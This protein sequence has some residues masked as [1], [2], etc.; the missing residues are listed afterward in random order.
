MVGFLTNFHGY[1][2]DIT[3]NW[4]DFGDLDLIVKVTAVEK[5]KMHNCG[6]GGGGGGGTSV[7]S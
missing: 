6:G 3:K 2:G 1:N 4:L 5:L 7:F